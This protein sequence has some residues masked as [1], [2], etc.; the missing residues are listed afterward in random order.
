[1]LIK[2]RSATSPV[3]LSYFTLFLDIKIAHVIF[4]PCS[5]YT[6]VKNDTLVHSWMKETN[7]IRCGGIHTFIGRSCWDASPKQ[8]Q[9]VTNPTQS[10]TNNV[11]AIETHLRT[12]VAICDVTTSNIPESPLSSTK[13]EWF[14]EPE[15]NIKYSLIEPQNYTLQNS[16]KTTA[17]N[18][19]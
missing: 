16:L 10:H 1:M 6:H 18:K 8:M 12:S 11:L 5:L 15:Y 3:I 17:E 2:A 7:Y 4:S 19:L 9:R 14:N 13:T